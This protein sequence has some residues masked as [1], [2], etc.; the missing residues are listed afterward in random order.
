LF[1][2]YK[3]FILIRYILK[4]YVKRITNY[5]NKIDAIIFLNGQIP[6]KVV[7]KYFTNQTYIICADGASNS[8]KK[9][10]IK[11]NIILGDM[12]SSKK[13][14]V[15][16]YSKKGV[17]IRKIEDQETTDFEKSLMYCIENAL[18]NILIFGA[19][20]KRQ[21]HTLNNYSVLK[22]YYKSLNLK[23]ID[24]KFEIFFIEKEISFEYPKK[25]SIS[26]MP[27]PIAKGI[28]TSGLK[29][30]LDN[31]DLELGIREGTLNISESNCINIEF[32]SGDL[33]LFKRHF[34]KR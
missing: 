8:L 14:T 20:S 30:K 9:Q 6:F 12:D 26:I 11:P 17:E 16:H 33:L 15:A 5:M 4:F 10:G 7:K 27:M 29:Y 23:M 2:R 19:S 25:K 31:E 3:G 34:H 13:S 32:T 21:D 18:K 24:N 1:L 22:R 28:T